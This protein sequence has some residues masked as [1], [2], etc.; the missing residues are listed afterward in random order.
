MGHL[1]QMKVIVKG[2]VQGVG[3]R[4]ATKHRANELHLTGFVRNLLDGSV[5]I[6]AQGRK[7]DLEELLR[8]LMQRFRIGEMKPVFQE[9]DQ[10]EAMKSF[11]IVR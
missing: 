2:D 6:M 3:F 1:M 9:I 5:E 4:F 7:E 10:T 11:E 8:H